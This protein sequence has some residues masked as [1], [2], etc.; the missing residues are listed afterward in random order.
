[1]TNLQERAIVANAIAQKTQTNVQGRDV[2][3]VS[4]IPT[5]YAM[6]KD[7]ETILCSIDYD[8]GTTIKVVKW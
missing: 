3:C 1:M 5:V 7:S 8:G 6:Q 4:R 2:V